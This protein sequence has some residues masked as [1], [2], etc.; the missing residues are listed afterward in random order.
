LGTTE[1]TGGESLGVRATILA[2]GGA[3]HLILKVEDG[4]FTDGVD[5]D[6]PGLVRF[7]F[8]EIR[9]K[10]IPNSTLIIVRALRFA[11]LNLNIYY[12]QTFFIKRVKDIFLV[13]N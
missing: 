1:T 13:S 11:L 8:L 4:L 3:L 6:R 12:V 7:T 9:R 2:T 5:L 10:M